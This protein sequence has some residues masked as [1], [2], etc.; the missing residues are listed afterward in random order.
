VKARTASEG[1]RPGVEPGQC[2]S[3]A[4]WAALG[5]EG[6]GPVGTSGQATPVEG[7]GLRERVVERTTLLAALARVKRH[8]GSP[9]MDRMTVEALPGDLKGPWPEIRQACWRERTSRNR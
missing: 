8:G 4:A 5:N 1:E 6:E 7:D 9:G 2:T 3:N